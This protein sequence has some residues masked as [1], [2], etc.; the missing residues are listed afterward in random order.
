MDFG[1]AN[2]GSPTRAPGDLREAGYELVCRLGEGGMGE[3][4]AAA[5][6]GVAGAIKPCAIKVIRPVFAGDE[7]YRRLFVAEGRVAMMLG[8]ANIVSVFDVGVVDELLF[9]AMDWVDGIDLGA[10]R[11]QVQLSAGGRPL[12]VEDAAHVVGALLDALGYAHGFCIAGR[13]HGIVHRDVSPGNVMIT[14]RGEVKLMD[15]GLAGVARLEQARREGSMPRLRGTLRYLSREQARGRPEPASDLFAVGAI[16][17][18]LLDGRKFRHWCASDQALVAEIF[19]GGIPPLARRVPAPIEALRRGLLEPRA[20]LRIKTARRALT[21]LAEWSGY[22][23]RRLHLES[24][25]RQVIGEPRSGLTQLL[26]LGAPSELL[27]ELRQRVAAGR[28]AV[29]QV[30]DDVRSARSAV[31]SV[32]RRE[33][34]RTVPYPAAKGAA[35]AR[36]A[37][38]AVVHARPAERVSAHRVAQ[39][40]AADGEASV[41]DAGGSNGAGSGSGSGGDAFDREITEPWPREAA[42]GGTKGCDASG[43]RWSSEGAGERLVGGRP[44]VAVL[45]ALAVVLGGLSVLSMLVGGM[46]AAGCGDGSEA[47]PVAERGG[48]RSRW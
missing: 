38:E 16:L 48:G 41:S 18:E 35:V 15:F 23:N 40:A 4:W 20:E 6:F 47:A 27:D 37:T 26:S 42:V 19:E 32:S 3:V 43:E 31:G 29:P 24:L 9:M 33:A 13:E 8:H 46:T 10:F 22:R 1:V 11:H 28:I 14:S 7:Q 21:T 12:A 36:E 45:V 34:L 2:G 25:Y 44:R 17:H 30:V 39:E 5:R